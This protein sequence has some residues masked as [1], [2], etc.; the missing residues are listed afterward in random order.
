MLPIFSRVLKRRR[1]DVER[2]HDREAEETEDP[3]RENKR[4]EDAVA[5]FAMHLLGYVP[6]ADKSQ[7]TGDD[8]RIHGIVDHDRSKYGQ[9]S[10][11]SVARRTKEQETEHGKNPGTD[12]QQ[13]RI[14]I[15][16]KHARERASTGHRLNRGID[17]GHG[18]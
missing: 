3:Q 16:A 1:I 9:V 5:A 13:R 15:G 8:K 7:R 14:Q 11:V 2:S 12:N 17:A 6:A 10:A 18:S 4:V